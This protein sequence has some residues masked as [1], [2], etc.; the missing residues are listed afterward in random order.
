[1]APEFD[2]AGDA[3]KEGDGVIIAKVDADAER[4]LGE[5]F[6]V[7]GFPTLKWFP[8]G[9]TTGEEYD[10]GR[11]ADTIVSWVNGKTGLSRKIKK[12]P[13][14][15]VDLTPAT[16]DAVVDG[17]SNVLV[18]FKAAW[19]GHCKTL[20]PKFETLAQIFAGEKDVVVAQ[21]DAAEHRDLGS[22]FDVSGYPTLKFFPKGKKEAEAYEQGREVAD[23]VTFLNE[24]AGT[25]YTATGGLLPS[26]GRIPS[27]DALVA[28]ATAISEAT[29]KKAKA[30]AAKLQGQAKEHSDLY[31]KAIEKVVAKGADY[32]DTEA[33][34]LRKLISGGN[35]APDKKAFFQLKA[36]ILRAF[37]GEPA[38][39]VEEVATEL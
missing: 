1:M 26:A 31:L 35:I 38:E 9:S 7:K 22:R 11:T 14:A 34:R 5:R 29:L 25:A 33:E 39:P 21:V 15:V 4:S 20:A 30:V 36:N 13:T 16:F 28:E 24:K 32:I 27:L 18:A 10:G 3:Y 37:K 23:F 19:C 17:S 2:L 8:K 6:E 12:A